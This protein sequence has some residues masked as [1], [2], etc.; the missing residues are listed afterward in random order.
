MNSTTRSHLFLWGG[1]AAATF[2]L[3]RAGIDPTNID[4]TTLSQ[5]YPQIG[6]ILASIF[7]AWKGAQGLR[8][9]PPAPTVST[10]SNPEAQADI[11]AKVH[12]LVS[13]GRELRSQPMVDAALMYYALC[14]KV[15]NG[16]QSTD[17]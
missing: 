16:G 15:D 2:F 8:Q 3:S 1:V 6:A 14:T 12:A 5:K 9:A 10:A 17:P 4:L 11:S 13:Y 7:A